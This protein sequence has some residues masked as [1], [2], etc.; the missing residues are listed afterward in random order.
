MRCLTLFC[1]LLFT[2]ALPAQLTFSHQIEKNGFSD[3]LKVAAWGE[4]YLIKTEQI[5]TGPLTSSDNLLITGG[6]GVVRVA[7]SFNPYARSGNFTRTEFTVLTDSSA[8]ALAFDNSEGRVSLIRF[9]QAGNTLQSREFL[10]GNFGAYSLCSVADS[11]VI[12]VETDLGGAGEGSFTVRAV[13]AAFVDKYDLTFDEE[14]ASLTFNAIYAQAD[15]LLYIVYERRREF[16]PVGTEID[17]FVATVAANGTLIGEQMIS[18]PQRLGFFHTGYT[19]V[20]PVGESGI[21]VLEGLR[22]PDLA[23]AGSVCEE[24]TGRMLVYRDENAAAEVYELNFTPFGIELLP[25]GEPFAYGTTTILGD[26][27]HGV[28]FKPTGWP[29]GNR[30]HLLAAPFTSA[31]NSLSY[32]RIY[33]MSVAGNG[34][35]IG[36]GHV[37]Y[38]DDITNVTGEDHWL[39]RMGVNGCFTAD[40]SDLQEDPGDLVPVATLSR[41]LAIIAFP[42]P[43]TETLNFTG[44]ENLVGQS[45]TISLHDL[46]GRLLRQGKLGTGLQW[47][48]DDL[49]PGVYVATL[50]SGNQRTTL[51]L[52]KQ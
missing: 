49:T 27:S 38:V 24:E 33:G 14:N 47:A 5:N 37:G 35:L 26:E 18:S 50:T 41:E 46:S 7:D 23:C 45:V 29:D 2:T 20:R 31:T 36:V 43:F 48:T 13:S 6:D 30:I 12:F 11:V 9:D 1:L 17:Y 16:P 3:A 32:S 4:A 19:E 34:D 52:V 8:V 42:N 25:D 15:G 51:K 21:A 22:F 10:A 40:C 28:L 44:A 39:F